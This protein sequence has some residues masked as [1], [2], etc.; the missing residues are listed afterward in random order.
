MNREQWEQVKVIFGE[1]LDRPQGERESYIRTATQGQADLLAELL[2]MLKESERES[3]LLS[4]PVLADAKAMSRDEAPRFAPAALLARRYRIVRFIARGG[5]GEVYEAED[6][7][8]G[9]RVALKAIRQRADDTIDLRSLFKREIQMARR[10]T[11]PNVC[12]IF[13]LAQHEDPQRREP[14]LL[15]SMELIEGQS[16]TEYLR[17]NG[18]LNFRSALLLIDDIA[19]GLQAI[20]DAGIIHGDLKPGNVMLS[21]RPGET[22]PHARVMD[23]GM[24]VPTGHG[25]EFVGSPESEAGAHTI[26]PGENEQT[27]TLRPSGR[28]FV[29]GTPD[30]LAP[31]QTKG[32]PASTATDVY[33][34]A[35]VIGEMLGVPREKRFEP[36]EKMPS[37]WAQ[38]LR[39][40]LESDPAK[41]YSGPAEVAE[42]LHTVLRAGSQRKRLV[43]IAVCAMLAIVMAAK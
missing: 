13:D 41:R 32:A 42:A 43:V 4:R 27:V 30:F 23:F 28:G 8:L 19:A 12:R 6:L 40:C 25:T 7:E 14:V 37:R 18:P 11:H 10:V 3:D 20:H 15:L 26:S 9:E 38:V 31:E 35:L 36:S 29:G 5:M 17:S 1:A 22:A 24:A 2:R 21:L 39:R 16:L 33:A 34:F